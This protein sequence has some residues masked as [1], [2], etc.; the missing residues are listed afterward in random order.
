MR[1]PL[2]AVLAAIVRYRLSWRTCCHDQNP[3]I[4]ATR[5]TSVAAIQVLT[6]KSSNMVLLTRTTPVTRRFA[7]RGRGRPCG[8]GTDH[9]RRAPA[10]REIDGAVHHRKHR[11]HIM[12]G[13][14]PWSEAPTI[15]GATARRCRQRC[16]CPDW[17]AVRPAAADADA[18]SA[19]A[20]AAPVVAVRGT[21][22]RS[23]DRRTALRPRCMWL[24]R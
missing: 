22:S 23:A 2:A 9:C 15:G 4:P 13:E 12:C 7:V 14:Q 6:M 3:T 24:S 1:L 19:R 18:G 17:R 5:A 16:A 11:V 8:G 10:V 20:R 21:G